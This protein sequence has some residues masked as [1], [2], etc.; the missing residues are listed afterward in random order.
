MRE[1]GCYLA[2]RSLKISR[3]KDRESMPGPDID[4]IS[5]VDALV[6]ALGG[7]LQKFDDPALGL[8]CD[9]FTRV[10]HRVLVDAQIDH[11]CMG[12]GVV[13]R[14][15]EFRP[16]F[17]IEVEADAKIIVIDFHWKRWFPE[18]AEHPGDDELCRQG[19]FLL[20]DTPKE[21][22]Q[23]RGEPVNIPYLNSAIF[24]VLTTPFEMER[25]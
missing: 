8:E 4:D 3:F 18:L 15:R 14:G 12:G 6:E 21:L 19:V 1:P 5:D 17:W 24:R 7:L 13:Y 16:H 23:Y 9:G 10:A 11:R 2:P 22:H 25:D 20:L